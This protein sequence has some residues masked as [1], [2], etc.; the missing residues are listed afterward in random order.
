[1]TVEEAFVGGFV[2]FVAVACF[3]IGIMVGWMT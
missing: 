2:I 1:M 3:L